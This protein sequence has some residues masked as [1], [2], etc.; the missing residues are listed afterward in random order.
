[1]PADRREQHLDG[2]GWRIP[3]HD[4]LV[5][6]HA[7]TGEGRHPLQLTSHLDRVVSGAGGHIEHLV[8]VD[9]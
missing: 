1:M 8:A 3:E 4:V 7:A 5:G 2:Q 6:R 9:L